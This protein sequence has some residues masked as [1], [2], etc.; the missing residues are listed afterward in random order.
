MNT[1]AN[2]VPELPA[3]P[4]GT[5]PAP[6]PAP[7][8]S[9]ATR[10][11]YWSV[12]R[13]L[14]ENRSI[15]VAPLAAAAVVLIGFLISM[16]GQP[17]RLRAALALD[18]QKQGIAIA[19][20]Y[21]VAA[22]L[23]VLTSLL[24]AVFYCLD[25][26]HGERRDRTILFWKSLPVSDLTTV[27]AKAGIPLVVL[28]L[29]TFA[30]I[31]ALQLV[32][33]LLST[34][35]L[36]ASGLAAEIP[37]THWPLFQESLVLLYGLAVAALWYAPFYGWLLLVSA[38]ARRTTFL[39]AVLTPLAICVLEAIAFRTSHFASMLKYRLAGGFGAAFVGGQHGDPFVGLAQ[40][41]PV[42][43]L[44]TPGLWI[45]LAVAAAFLAAVVWLRRYRDPI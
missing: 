4:Q 19:M 39:W 16:V 41:D 11:L 15:Y 17:D 5:A 28:P 33:L 32:M 40:L 22:I 12:R 30:T 18:P 20:P 45:G 43:F 24:V 29:V 26:L 31:V 36:L 35:T 7:S 2:T 8:A 1:P 44:S 34:A 42:K 13:E 37:W 38:W 9:S 10:P 3:D 6:M 14:W 23:V 21:N 27:L 25:A